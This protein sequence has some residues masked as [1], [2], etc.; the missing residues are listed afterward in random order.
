ML[1]TIVRRLPLAL[2]AGL[3]MFLASHAAAGA[4]TT[5]ACG[6]EYMRPLNLL[7]FSFGVERP[8]TS[9]VR[10]IVVTRQL[11]AGIPDADPK[12]P[13]SSCTFTFDKGSGM[14]FNGEL[15]SA[16]TIHSVLWMASLNPRGTSATPSETIKYA[17]ST[18]TYSAASTMVP[19]APKPTSTVK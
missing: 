15:V 12:S 19:P 9:N 5:V 4:A 18:I 7:S 14:I 8:T 3:C 13:I 2:A 17:F 16:V 11:A 10:Q 1:V 6:T